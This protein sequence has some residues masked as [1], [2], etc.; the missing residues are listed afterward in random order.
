[1]FTHVGS[2]QDGKLV[3]QLKIIRNKSNVWIGSSHNRMATF[4][5]FQ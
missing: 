1:M 5:K 2:S 3:F 4:D